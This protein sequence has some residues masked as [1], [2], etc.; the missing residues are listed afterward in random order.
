[1][2][3]NQYK[4][5]F[6][7]PAG[8]EDWFGRELEAWREVCREY[9]RLEPFTVR[10]QRPEFVD[11]AQLA[12]TRKSMVRAAF[13]PTLASVTSNCRMKLRREPLVNEAEP[14]SDVNFRI[15]HIDSVANVREQNR[16]LEFIVQERL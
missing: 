5:I 7:R 15:F 13:S 12:L 10:T 16:E 11:S 8:P 4:A 6:E 3:Q 9:V 1:M 2:R 14:D